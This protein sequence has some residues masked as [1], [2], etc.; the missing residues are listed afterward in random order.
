MAVG[1][2]LF[3]V[4]FWNQVLFIVSLSHHMQYVYINNFVEVANI[5]FSCVHPEVTQRPSMGEVAGNPQDVASSTDMNIVLFWCR[6]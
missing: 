4:K 1:V 6:A 2:Y 3:L 5:A